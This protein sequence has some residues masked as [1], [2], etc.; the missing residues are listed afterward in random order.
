MAEQKICKQCQ[1]EFT[2]TDEDLAFYEKISPVFAGNKY[3]IAPPALCPECRLRRRLS[4]RNVR[5]LYRR[6]S[7]LSGKYLIS[8]YAPNLG[9]KVI[10]TEEFESDGFDA[11]KYGRDYD[12]NRPFFEQFGDLLKEVPRPH[13]TIS[14][15]TL[16][17]A[18]FI[19]GASFT[20]NAY[21][22]FNLVDDEDIYYCDS[23]FHSKDCVDCLYSLKIENC[24][25]CIDC[26]HLYGCFYCLDCD[27]S[28]E[29]YFC[30]NMNS[31]RNCFGC[32]SLNSKQYYIYNK[33][34]SKEEFAGFINDFKFTPESIEKAMQKMVELDLKQ[35]HKFA[36]LI[37]CESCTGNYL[38]N[39]NNCK[40][41]FGSTNVENVKYGL[42]LDGSVKD[43]MDV[44]LIYNNFELG[45][46]DLTSGHNSYNILFSSQCHTNCRDIYYSDCCYRGNK[47]LFGCVGLMKSEYCILNKEYSKENYE[48][49]VAKII[50]HMQKNGEWG[51]FFPMSLSPYGYNE[52]LG[53]DM[54]PLK[55]EEAK[56]LGAN[57]QDDSFDIKY[58]GPFYKPKLIENYDPKN[59]LDA[60][61]EIDSALNGIV[62]CSE[63]GRPFRLIAQ[64]IAFYVDR[65]LPIPTVHPELRYKK[66]YA[67]T[68]PAVLY[69]RQCMCEEQDHGHE[70]R[71]KNEFETTYAPDRPEKVYC[72]SCYQKSI[73]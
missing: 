33:K 60:K 61:T 5:K 68:M 54:F 50:E 11:K 72:E 57:W 64:E 35:P 14:S 22:S 30:N 15:G 40:T 21:M 25:E 28:H 53:S 62:R 2:V 34:V 23:L 73:I 48:I 51:E 45:L 41:C 18:E 65:G 9:Y 17:N 67:K 16:E 13:A 36:R 8:C 49:L 20:K 4:F 19:N 43:S 71:C 56:R 10:S 27:D 12:F 42:T 46:E 58:D 70:G 32:S 55:K 1:K 39:A 69:H 37:N 29:L 63:S 47:N 38:T 26:R 52:T 24:Y 6:K 66:R 44:A 7:E 59:N 3:I 31:C